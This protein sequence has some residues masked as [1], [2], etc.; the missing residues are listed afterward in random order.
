MFVL[1][2]VAG[3]GNAADMK[4]WAVSADK[5]CVEDLRAE[6]VDLQSNLTTQQTR[7]EGKSTL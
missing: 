4:M 1:L 7:L 5:V 3:G 6:E 2:R